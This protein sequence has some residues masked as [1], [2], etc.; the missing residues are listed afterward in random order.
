MTRRS[1]L[2]SR[3]ARQRRAPSLPRRLAGRPPAVSP[4]RIDR[5][6]FACYRLIPIE[7]RR[8]HEAPYAVIRLRETRATM[9]VFAFGPGARATLVRVRR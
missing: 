2:A 6:G 1:P 4:P 8:P 9:G 5:L 7:D 3:P